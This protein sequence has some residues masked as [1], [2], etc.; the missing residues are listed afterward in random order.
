MKSIFKPG[1]KVYH[2]S[3]GWLSVIHIY[4]DG[5]V[6]ASNKKD[7]EDAWTFK[8]CSD[9]IYIY[10]VD[11]LSFTEY[12]FIKGGFSQIRKKQN[13]KQKILN[14]IKDYIEKY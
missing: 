3:L 1:D 5:S 13:L 14:W 7:N 10:R 11:F 8:V 6:Y 4:N 2:F 12:N 9:P